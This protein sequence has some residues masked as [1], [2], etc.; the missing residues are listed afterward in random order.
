MYRAD[1]RAGQHRIGGLGDHGQVQDNAVT[2]AHAQPLEHI[3]HPRGLLQQLPVGDMARGLGGFVGLKDNG[4]FIGGR[5]RMAVDA[6]G[7][8]VER[9]VFVP[10]DVH[11][12]KI[13]AGVFYLG[14]GLDPVDPFAVLA[15][16]GLGVCDGGGVHCLIRRG[17]GVGVGRKF[18]TGGIGLIAHRFLRL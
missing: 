18:C 9:A 1:P 10:F 4:G 6:V 16:K 12:A 2:F 15:P 13:V 17:I 7:R 5:R 14:V 11:V 3:G 8:N